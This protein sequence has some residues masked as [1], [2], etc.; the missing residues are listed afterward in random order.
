MKH[1]EIRSIEHKGI[2]VVI[3]IDYDK[4]TASLVEKYDDRWKEKQFLFN[5]R[6][7][8]YMNGWQKILEAMQVAV[9]ECRKELENDLAE[10]TKFR[11]GMVISGLIK[12]KE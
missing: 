3:K 9:T 8:E 6:G 5:A 12:G 2:K 10:K 1:L 11:E 4:G 7:L